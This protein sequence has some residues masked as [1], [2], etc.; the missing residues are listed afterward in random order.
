MNKKS[1]LSL[2]IITIWISINVL[3]LDAIERNQEQFSTNNNYVIAPAPYSVP[4]I[5]QGFLLVAYAGNVFE[6]YTDLFITKTVGDVEG[7]FYAVRDLHLID[8]RLFFEMFSGDIDKAA[9]IGYK[10][11]GMDSDQDDYNILE[12]SDISFRG[13][14]ATLSYLDRMLEL[15]FQYAYGAASFNRILDKD[16]NVIAEGTEQKNEFS[17]QMYTMTV[18]YT[19]DLQDPKKGVRLEVSYE[20]AGLEK[21]SES[22]P[23]Q[24]IVDYNLT[25]YIPVLSF[26]TLALNYFQSDAF[27]TK[28]GETDLTIIEQDLGIDCTGRPDETE[29]ES[30]KQA[31]IENTYAENKYGTASN[32]GG[33]MRLR[34]YPQNRFRA[35]H[36][37]FYGTEFRWNLSD[38]NS[39]FD[40]FFIKDIRTGTQLAL[41]YETATSADLIGDLGKTWKSDYG[42]G[43]R[44][45]TRSG[46]VYRFDLA[47]GDEG[48]QIAAFFNYPWEGF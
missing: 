3:S 39:P 21:S 36:Q 11:R 45:I 47:Q 19:D 44:L 40:L 28:E 14:S 22:T 20:N 12:S 2:L 25:I 23:E 34:G 7:L 38:E 24:Y 30:A 41:F 33:A 4:G 17:R 35:A 5:G 1:I 43:F 13:G 6:G 32:L 31:V 42:V 27:I 29:C 10:Q 16:G 15:N 18:D 26:S 46:F 37:R 8:R 9:V 48:S